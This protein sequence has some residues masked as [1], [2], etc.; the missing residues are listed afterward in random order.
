MND[1]L[2]T[3]TR[4]LQSNRGE[5]NGHTECSTIVQIFSPVTFPYVH[6]LKLRPIAICVVQA[7]LARY[8]YFSVPV[9]ESP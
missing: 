2:R 7:D 5:E 9:E 3:F 8:A 6:R 1:D 4:G